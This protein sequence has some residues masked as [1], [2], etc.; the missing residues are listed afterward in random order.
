MPCGVLIRYAFLSL[1]PLMKRTDPE[2]N[3][4]VTFLAVPPLPVT[5]SI[6]EYEGCIPPENQL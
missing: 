3:R 4:S 2:S 6:H 5:Y 1:A